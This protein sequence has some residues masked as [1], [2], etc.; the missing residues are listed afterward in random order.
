MTNTIDRF[1][2]ASRV[3]HWL[4]AISF[5][6]LVLS[7]LGL[8]AHT[9]FG[10]FDLFGGPQQGIVV[11]KWAGI[12]FLIGSVLLFLSHA[13]EVC[14]FDADDRRWIARLGGYLSRNAEEIPQGKFNAGQK[15]F[16]IFAVIAALV[17]GATGLVIWDPTAYSR[18]L[19]QASF[20]LHSIFFN[21]FMV[22]MIV[23]VY[24]ATIGNPGT[25]EGMLYGQVRRSW[26]KKHA[27]K[28][29]EKVAKN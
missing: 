11:H 8:Y 27:G 4:V 12:V 15:L 14:R 2:T 6:L 10:Y 20:L 19:T 29:F 9:F 28:W 16:G 7:G 24:L 5:L 22:G 18:E 25:L 26:A 1:G 21:L 3:L 17:M 13:G 23:H